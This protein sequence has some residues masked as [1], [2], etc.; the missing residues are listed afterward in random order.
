MEADELAGN[1]NRCR[2]LKIDRGLAS[3][4]ASWARPRRR[5]LID[6]AAVILSSAISQVGIGRIDR[7]ARVE[8]R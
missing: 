6:L 4:T 5:A 3:V 2:N 7:K 8:L 1:I